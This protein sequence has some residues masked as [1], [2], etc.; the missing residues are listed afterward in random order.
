LSAARPPIAATPLPVRLLIAARLSAAFSAVRL[1]IAARLSAAFSASLLL[2]TCAMTVSLLLRCRSRQAAA[3]P[4]CTAITDGSTMQ[5]NKRLTVRN[6]PQ[7]RDQEK[8]R[9]EALPSRVEAL[10]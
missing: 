9:V 7:S 8:A 4:C 3:M 10:W 5:C 1:L 2:A 6:P